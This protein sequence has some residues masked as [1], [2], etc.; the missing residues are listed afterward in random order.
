MNLKKLSEN[1][2]FAIEDLLRNLK[3]NKYLNGNIQFTDI[4]NRDC[5]LKAYGGNPLLHYMGHVS[6]MERKVPT[7]GQPW[8]RRRDVCGFYSQDVQ[9]R[10]SY[11]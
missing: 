10:Q 1:E 6:S 2:R 8:A 5:F 4:T 11:K 7:Y 9:C 3:T